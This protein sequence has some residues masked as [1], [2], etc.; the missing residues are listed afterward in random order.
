MA[1]KIGV[2]CRFL[3][4][5]VGLRKTGQIDELLVLSYWGLPMHTDK[6]SRFIRRFHIPSSIPRI[7]DVS[8]VFSMLTVHSVYWFIYKSSRVREFQ[9]FQ[10]VK[11]RIHRN[12]YISM[13]IYIYKQ[14]SLKQKLISIYVVPGGGELKKLGL[15]Y[16]SYFLY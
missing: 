10:G 13:I 1:T 9:F 11:Y 7:F 3:D 8:K 4:H 14:V 2:I 16:S 12:I 6:G 15:V 5:C